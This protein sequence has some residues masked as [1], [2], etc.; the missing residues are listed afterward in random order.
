MAGEV[1]AGILAHSLA[2][3]SDAAHMH[4]RKRYAAVSAADVVISPG[5]TKPVS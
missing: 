4:R 5:L 3:L 1:V 2:P